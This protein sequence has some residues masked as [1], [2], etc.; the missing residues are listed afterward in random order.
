MADTRFPQSKKK[1]STNKTR[2]EFLKSA[3]EDV[4]QD[5]YAVRGVRSG[6]AQAVRI[7]K[8]PRTHALSKNLDRVQ[9]RVASRNTA[10]AASHVPQPISML[11]DQRT[12]EWDVTRSR[13]I[14]RLIELGL[15]KLILQANTNLLVAAVKEVLVQE[16]RRFFS[17]ITAILFRMFLILCQVLHVQKNL[18]ARSGYQKRLSP[19]FDFGHS[20]LIMRRSRGRMSRHPASAAG[21]SACPGFCGRSTNPVPSRSRGARRPAYRQRSVAACHTRRPSRRRSVCAAQAEWRTARPGRTGRADRAWCGRS[22]RRTIAAGSQ[23]Q[24]DRAPRGR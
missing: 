4:W 11:I 14:L 12:R 10:I 9:K 1:D 22:P 24:D 17:R 18:L 2:S 15:E 8:P 3:Y 20:A 13:A 6:S 23:S 21:V 19:E 7:G 5:T 16:C